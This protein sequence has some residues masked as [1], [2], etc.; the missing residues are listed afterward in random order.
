MAEY[1]VGGV[2]T[3]QECRPGKKLGHH[4]LVSLQTGSVILNQ[5]LKA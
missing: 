3:R 2:T 5:K 1:V 4:Q